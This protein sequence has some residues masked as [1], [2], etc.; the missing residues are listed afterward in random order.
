MIVSTGFKQKILAA[1][2]SIFNGGAIY[3]YSGA[4]PVSPDDAITGTLLGV[5]TDEGRP[6]SLINGLRYLAEGP[7]IVY[8]PALNPMLTTVA[9]GNATWFRVVSADAGE[10]FLDTSTLARID[11][12]IEQSGSGVI[13][14]MYLDNVSLVN[15]QT[16]ESNY[17]LYTIFPL[18]V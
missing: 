18:P 12:T 1:F 3:V 2:P 17:L 9:A 6:Y 4:K 8:D 15:G 10:N 13:A 11:G 5:I 16:I 14:D 7:Y